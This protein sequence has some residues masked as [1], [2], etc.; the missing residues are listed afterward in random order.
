MGRLCYAQNFSAVTAACM[1]VSKEIFQSVGGFDERFAVAYNDVDLCLKIAEAG[2]RNVWTPCAEAY[3]YE[4][5]SRGYESTPEKQERFQR[6]V[7]LFR[8]KWGEEIDLGDPYYNKNFSLDSSD[9]T[10]QME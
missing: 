3:H 1:L 9:F 6:E 10:P 4:S 5:V 7:R 2:Y 8:E